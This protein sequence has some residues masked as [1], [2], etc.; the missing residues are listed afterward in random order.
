VLPEDEL[1]ISFSWQLGEVGPVTT[2]VRVTQRT[3]IT[4]RFRTEA[5]L[6]RVLEYTYQ[7]RNFLGLAVGRPVL[8]LSVRGL[9]LPP[10][11]AEPDAVTGVAPQP[12]GVDIYYRLS[13]TP[14]LGRKLLPQQMLFT[15]DDARPRLETLLNNWLI[16]H[17]ILRPVFDLYFGA[18]YS[19]HSY[20][21]QTFLS[22]MQALETYHRRTSSE[23]E[24]PQGRHQERLDAILDSVPAQY[25]DWLNEKLLYSNE[26]TLRRR[27]KDVLGRCPLVVD[28][29]VNDKPS[30]VNGLL[31]TR[32]YRTHYDKSLEYKALQGT[33]LYPFVVRIR[34]LVEMCLLLELGFSCEEIAAIFERVDR[35]AEIRNADQN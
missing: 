32:N 4:V 1:V 7:L 21:E 14:P 5:S 10:P 27:L 30:F 9:I 20:L 25:R 18:T 11:E 19:P 35:Y 33:A 15:L 8:P 17:E 6:K 31:D 16:K 23:T 34:S 22:L 3:R 2:D 13:S 28:N 29:L 12:I 26:L 24:L